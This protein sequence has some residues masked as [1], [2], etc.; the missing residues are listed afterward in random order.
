MAAELS[1]NGEPKRSAWE[2]GACPLCGARR[3]GRRL[4]RFELRARGALNGPGEV[5]VVRC[6]RCG[7]GYLHPRLRE[8]TIHRV[9]ADSSYFGAGIEFG[10]ADYAGQET[11]LRRTFRAFLR[12]LQ[13]RGHAGGR[14]ADI[15]CGPG[16]LLAEAQPLFPVRMGT[17]MSPELARRASAVSDGVICGGPDDLADEDRRFDTVTAVSVLEHIYRPSVFLAACARLLTD[18]GVLVVVVPN[19]GSFWRRMM[20]RHWPSFKI[21]E[22]IA[23][24]EGK[25]LEILAGRAG[26]EVAGAFPY[27]HF[28]PLGL[29]LTKLGLGVVH[30]GRLLDRPVFLPAVMMAAVL[31]KKV[32]RGGA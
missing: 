9:Y 3:I 16:Y 10:Y 18:D 1:C 32:S 22:H 4:Y 17:E 21:P 12:A 2:D 11:A 25:T 30:L 24:Y 15:G 26:M 31:R 13:R 28:F 27:H 29:I 8:E 14:L 5:G 20:G 23:Y 7:L 19:L 6:G